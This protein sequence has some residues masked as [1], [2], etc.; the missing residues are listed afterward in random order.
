MTDFDYKKYSLE[1]LENWIS[2]AILSAEASPEE[3]YE[4]IVN[5]VSQE[6]DYFNYHTTRTYELLSLL[7]GNKVTDVLG[8]DGVQIDPAG[9][10]VGVCDSD[11]LSDYCKQSWNSFWQEDEYSIR[12]EEYYNKPNSTPSKWILPVE[13]DDASG[14]S[15]I[16]LPNDLLDKLEWKESDVLEYIDNQDGS[17]TLKKVQ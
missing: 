13:I 2:D 7:N 15:F 1:N 10:N 12:E 6:Y 3:I 14:E 17:F 9:N 8:F 16:T 4:T 11:N 5:A